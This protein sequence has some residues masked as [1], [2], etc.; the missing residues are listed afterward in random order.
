MFS[1]K[2]IGKKTIPT[3]YS[4]WAFDDKLAEKY[5]LEAV[6]APIINTT[7]FYDKCSALSWAEKATYPKVFKTRCGAGSSNVR[8][9]KNCAQ[10]KSIIKQAFSSKGIPNQDY[11][12]LLK[13]SLKNILQGKNDFYKLFRNTLLSICPSLSRE[14]RHLTPNEKGYVMFQDYI[15]NDGYD[16]RVI[17]IGDKAFA[18]KRLCRDGDF[19]ASGSGKIQY[20]K[21]LFDTSLI[22][23]S[24]E[25][26][27]KL[28]A[29]IINF[30]FIIDKQGNAK[31][32]EMN[33]GFAKKGYLPCEGYWDAN[34]EWHEG[35]NFDFCGWMVELLLK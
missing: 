15:E 6:G 12:N 2:L 3:V 22:K 26:S 32:C 29:N 14:N 34:L 28:K 33:Y 1:L 5:A 19:R 30:D 10:A 13:M 24:F 11:K 18:I 27:K 9:I 17:V 4:D 21:N 25:L 35:S 7:I 31:I 8:L 23:Q 20:S 16:I